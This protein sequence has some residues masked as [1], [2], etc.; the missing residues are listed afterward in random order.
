MLSAPSD[1]H[2]RATSTVTILAN[3][4]EKKTESCLFPQ[5]FPCPPSLRERSYPL[6][7][8]SLIFGRVEI[9]WVYWSHSSYEMKWLLISPLESTAAACACFLGWVVDRRKGLWRITAM[10]RAHQVTL[11]SDDSPM[12]SAFSAGNIR[13]SA[14]V[15]FLSFF[16]FD[17]MEQEIRGN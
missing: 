11:S 9:G 14:T 4:K 13:N 16:L 12:S 17:Y 7:F 1:R 8:C 15:P 2:G 10:K 6:H 3:I 5:V